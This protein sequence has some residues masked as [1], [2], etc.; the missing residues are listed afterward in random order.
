MGWD[1]SLS[2]SLRRHFTGRVLFDEPADIHTSIRAGGKIDAVFFPENQQELSALLRFLRTNHIPY[3]PIGNW[4]NLIV[5]DGG[6]RGAFILLSQFRELRDVFQGEMEVVI[7]A[8]AGCSLA[9][10]VQKAKE[11]SLAGME[12]CAGIP[13]SVG[14][15]IRMNAG[16]FGG[17]IKDVIELI[18]IT[19]SGGV[20][21][22]FSHEQLN[23]RYRNLVLPADAVITGG[24]FRLR[25]GDQ[26]KI[27]DRINTII[28]ERAKKHPLEFPNAGSIFK[29]PVDCPAGRLIEELGLK[30]V[31]IGDAQVSEKHGNFIVN[32]KKATAADILSL[33]EMVRR[34]VFEKTGRTLETEVKV[35]GEG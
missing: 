34:T 2:D 14:G 21:K 16:A 9:E 8:G 6:F 24:S 23:F 5:K 11:E 20:L 28:Q 25:R 4:T 32:R 3:L 10:L 19:D 22:T 26:R 33:I 12:F 13:G 35:V 1:D 29:N 31:S 30:G 15:A 27:G 7:F 18:A 17:E